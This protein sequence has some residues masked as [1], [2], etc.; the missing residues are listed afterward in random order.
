MPAKSSGRFQKNFKTR[1]GPGARLPV[2]LASAAGFGYGS[3]ARFGGRFYD[4]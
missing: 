4:E 1:P 3:L 2:Q